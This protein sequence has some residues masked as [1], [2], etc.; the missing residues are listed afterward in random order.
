MQMPVSLISGKIPPSESQKCHLATAH[1]LPDS[2]GSFNRLE[3]FKMKRYVIERS[4]P[5]VH[6]LNGEQRQGAAQASNAALAKLSGKAH[7]LHSY[8]A[9]DKTFCI[10]LAENEAAVREHAA[11]SGFPANKINEVL[12]ML[13]P[14]T[15]N[16]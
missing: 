3:I 6:K 15:A 5:G 1:R 13:E 11:L 7:W 2:D 4:I 14:E 12:G 9:D 16:A 10:Y 8:V